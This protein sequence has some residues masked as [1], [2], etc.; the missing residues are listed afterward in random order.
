MPNTKLKKESL[1]THFHYAKWFYVVIALG[2]FFL[3]DLLFTTTEYRSP[4]ERKVDFEIVGQYAEVETLQA[5]ADEI[6]KDAAQI[7]PTLEEIG[8]YHIAYSG[9]AETDIYGAQ[10]FMVM[11][12]AREGH[13]Y[14]LDRAL[15]EQLLAQDAI[16]PLDEYIDAGIL[17]ADGL[18]ME[19]VTFDEPVLDEGEQPSGKRYVYAIPCANLNR[20]R[21]PEI[22]YDNRDKYMVMMAYCPNPETTAKV[23]QRVIDELTAP[24]PMPAAQ[25]A[26]V[27]APPEEAAT[28]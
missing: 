26:E 2:A 28:P 4:P 21:T 1:K 9:D 20:M 27:S 17:K 8:M 18:D 12:A 3:G 7:D 23:M 19:S 15:M 14:M 10:K 13:V 25:P 24:D 22:S 6:M 11:I 5:V 16:L